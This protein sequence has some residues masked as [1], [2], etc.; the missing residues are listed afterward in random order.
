MNEKEIWA[1]IKD[2]LH[3]SDN[4][5]DIDEEDFKNLIKYTGF[6]PREVIRLI[7]FKVKEILWMKNWKTTLKRDQ[8]NC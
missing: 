2:Y 8:K 3:R 7:Q 4:K 5:F 6:I 1:L